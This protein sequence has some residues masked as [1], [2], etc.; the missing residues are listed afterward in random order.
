MD[1]YGM[2]VFPRF[3]LFSTEHGL[4]DYLSAAQ[5]RGIWREQIDFR[6]VNSIEKQ[7]KIK[8]TTKAIIKLLH[9]LE[10]LK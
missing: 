3:V 1:E 6:P 2:V 9:E 7:A 10:K 8:E 5:S 4:N